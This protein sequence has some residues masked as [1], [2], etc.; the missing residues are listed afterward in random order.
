MKKNKKFNISEILAME[1]EF[2]DFIN[3]YL[4]GASWKAYQQSACKILCSYQDEP[5]MQRCYVEGLSVS[6]KYVRAVGQ[7]V[8][9]VRFPKDSLLRLFESSRIKWL[10]DSQIRIS[11]PP[12]DESGMQHCYVEEWLAVQSSNPFPDGKYDFEQG[13]DRNLPVYSALFE[14]NLKTLELDRC[15]SRESR[16]KLNIN[17]KVR[18][19]L[20]D[21]TPRVHRWTDSPEEKEKIV[22]QVREHMETLRSQAGCLATTDRISMDQH[23][24]ICELERSVLERLLIWQKAGADPAASPGSS[25]QTEESADSPRHLL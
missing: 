16:S 5:G 18:A 2:P 9:L 17:I 12:L 13:T 7:K 8:V 25:V 14:L 21:L 24:D 19:G 4:T 1:N 3:L 11:C 20:M 22:D 15:I 23:S 10:S 6:V